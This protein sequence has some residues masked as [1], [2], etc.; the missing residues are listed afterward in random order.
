[1]L[2]LST[3]KFQAERDQDA[4]AGSLKSA[5]HACRGFQPPRY[6]MGRLD[7][8]GVRGREHR[9]HDRPQNDHL[10]PDGERGGGVGELRQEGEV[11]Q[12]GLGIQRFDD[13]AVPQRPAGRQVGGGANRCDD[14]RR[15]SQVPDAEPDQIGRSNQLHGGKQ[16]RDDL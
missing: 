11:E 2:L 4:A 3:C 12:H 14:G 5:H 9:I 10:G 15:V 7:E 16:P 1:M 8:D 13:D 6:R